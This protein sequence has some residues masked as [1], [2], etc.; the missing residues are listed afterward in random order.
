MGA[1]MIQAVISAM[2]HIVPPLVPPPMWNNQPLSCVPM[3]TGHNCF[4]AVLYPITMADFMIADVTDSMLDGVIAGFPNTYAF[5]WNFW[6]LPP[7]YSSFDEANP[8]PK[9]CPVVDLSD[10]D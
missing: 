8:F 7:Q 5:Y 1:G 10:F 9:D 4:G 3:V 2:V 6:R